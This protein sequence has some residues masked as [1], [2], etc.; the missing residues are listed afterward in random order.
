MCLYKAALP[1]DTVKRV[2]SILNDIGLKTQERFFGDKN[3]VCSAR[4]TL[5]CEGVDVFDIGTNGK[6]L[7]FDYALASAY[8]ELMERLQNKMLIWGIKYAT[9]QFQEN[10]V[11]LSGA[12][13]KRLSFRYFPDEIYRRITEKELNS[14]IKEW[15]LDASI[16]DS[17][18]KDGHN[19]DMPFLPFYSIDDDKVE[20][21]PYDIIRFAAGSTGLCAGNIPE[22]AILQ[23]LNEIFERYALQRLYLDEVYLPNIPIS[24]FAN[25][26][27]GDR[28]LNLKKKTGWEF[29]IKDCSLGIGFP[30]IGLLAI[31]I[32]KH[33]FSFRLGADLSED[34]ALQRCFSEM[35]QGCD[36]F[37]DS[38]FLPIDFSENWDVFDE[39][40]KNVV[41]GRGFIPVR[42]FLGKED[43]SYKG[44]G[45]SKG[46]TF[47]CRLHEI[48]KWLKEHN[49]RLYIRDNSF[50]GFPAY[51][52]YIPGLSNVDCRLYDVRKDIKTCDNY[53][54][55]QSEFDLKVIDNDNAINLIAKLKKDS[56][57]RI[58]L[59]F[60]NS[61]SLNFLDKNMTISLL[62]YQVGNEEDAYNYWDLF[63]K[64][65]E[66]K[67]QKLSEYYYCVRDMFGLCVSNMKHEEMICALSIIYPK[68]LVERVLDDMR[69]RNKV[70][71]NFPIPTCFRCWKC[72]LKNTCYYKL[73]IQIENR[74][75]KRQ[76]E[77]VVIQG[78][79]K[80]E[81][82]IGENLS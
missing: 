45:F 69:E 17:D 44:L 31:N 46:T 30:V 25:T 10:N 50:L 18:Y 51:H 7:D 21:L 53:Y 32:K 27:I 81:L 77:N 4:V 56:R 35:F 40:N 20:Y 65:R 70:F 1:Q 71:I 55:I 22:E 72:K 36:D 73:M 28:I 82:G 43:T 16:G 12:G 26:E 38:H 24:F 64:S 54:K 39:Y 5:D 3:I 62:S 37:D 58:P 23:G 9:H 78:M 67:S 15:L 2:K 41:N 6:G 8:G 11:S 49:Y 57:T 66:L 47:R 59:F 60:Y 14:L 48:L 42:I 80:E 34:I 74:I 19:F 33:T 63:L 68:G 29:I 13:I 75:Q 61:S 52:L 76:K 79:L